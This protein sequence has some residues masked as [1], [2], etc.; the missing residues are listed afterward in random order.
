MWK[1]SL[2]LIKI[3]NQKG[4]VMSEFNQ[5]NQN[6][7]SQGYQSTTNQ[8][9]N[10]DDFSKPLKPANNLALSIVATVLSLITCC[11]W[12]SCLGVI[13]GIIAIV[14]STQVDSK[15]ALGDYAGAENA[16]KY[17]KILSLVAIGTIVLSIVLI[18]VS[19]IV[20]GGVGAMMDQY[21][22][23]LEQYS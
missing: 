20:G 19:I 9:N 23:A 6:Y 22:E 14:F 1:L 5:E 18:I 7:Q 8:A 21:K 2:F 12:V 10:L 15:Y 11:G 17:A 4:T 16:A 13:L 3:I